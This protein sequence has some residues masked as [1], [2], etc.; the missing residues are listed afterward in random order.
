MQAR[1]R[2]LLIQSEIQCLKEHYRSRGMLAKPVDNRSSLEPAEEAV[3]T[4]E[5]A[6]QTDAVIVQ[7]AAAAVQTA[8]AGVQTDGAAADMQ[9]PAAVIQEVGWV[10][11]E[12]AD[13]RETSRHEGKVGP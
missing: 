5:V 9:P 4:D 1:D 11:A 10:M 13:C 8:E 2:E 12:V 6:V 3:Q 7:T